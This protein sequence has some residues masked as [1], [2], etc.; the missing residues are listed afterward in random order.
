MFRHVVLFTWK[1]DASDVE[2]RA[3]AEG[4]A[5]LP[6]RIPEIRSYRF[7]ADAGLAGGNEDFA[8][9]ADFDDA[10]AYRRYA[11]HPAHRHV[12]AEL[13]WPIL[14]GRHAVQYVI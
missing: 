11:E 8:L 13:L 2:I 14:G 9:V 5:A 6:G 3:F 12:I 10:E 7:G 1:A 4:L